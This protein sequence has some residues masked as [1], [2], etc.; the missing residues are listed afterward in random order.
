M[1][2][3]VF[4]VP[5]ARAAAP[6]NV[7]RL[8]PAARRAAQNTVSMLRSSAN[9]P[10]PGANAARRVQYHVPSA[11]LLA[12]VLHCVCFFVP[13]L[14]PFGA[15][16]IRAGSQDPVEARLDGSRSTVSG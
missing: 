4:P 9:A 6:V 11:H 16:L 15:A 12:L 5:P 1:G 10:A 7:S 8:A 3:G 13:G 2:P 14:R